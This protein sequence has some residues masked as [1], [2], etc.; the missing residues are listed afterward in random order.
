M[1]GLPLPSLLAIAIALIFTFVLIITVII[2]ETGTTPTW[3]DYKSFKI[4]LEHQNRIR[5]TQYAL[6]VFAI[7]FCLLAVV[8]SFL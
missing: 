8:L 5:K 3:M 7:G 1:Y 4:Y 6:G 2:T